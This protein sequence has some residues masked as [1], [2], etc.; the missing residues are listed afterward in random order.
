ML[1]SSYKLNQDLQ[2]IPM[3][4][5]RKITTAL[6]VKQAGKKEEVLKRV[7]AFVRTPEGRSQVYR[8]G[9]LPFVRRLGSILNLPLPREQPDLDTLL[10]GI[11]V[12]CLCTDKVAAP[13]DLIKCI[14]CG[15]SQH[16]EC[17]GRLVAMQEYHCPQC[18]LQSIEPFDKVV[19]TVVPATRVS[20]NS[21]MIFRYSD[22]E[23]IDKKL[24]LRCVL[25]DEN[26]FRQRWPKD[27]MVVLNKRLV[28]DFG[29]IASNETKKRIRDYPL[30]VNGLN[31][32]GENQIAVLSKKDP[33]LY[34]FGL[35]HVDSVSPESL[36]STLCTGELS[37]TEGKKFVSTHM[38]VCDEVYADT[39]YQVLRCPLSLLLPDLPV[40]G[41]Y[42]QHI[43][44]FD[45]ATYIVLQQ[46]DHSRRWKCPMCQLPALSVI[47][48]KYIGKI[49][50]EAKEIG[51]FSVEFESTGYYRLVLEEDDEDESEPGVVK[52]TR[53]AIRKLHW[54]DFCTRILPQEELWCSSAYTRA[55]LC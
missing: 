31:S 32:D 48:D 23:N 11:H 28:E 2:S 6:G 9:E 55:R 36:I 30:T 18:Q 39:Y 47:Q 17:I 41:Q 40:R 33:D 54:R 7:L 1:N 44:C 15:N 26:G 27:C 37:E 3:L 25:F 46:A 52:R 16:K 24:Q 38:P 12:I 21:R 42:C 53:Y 29:Q 43:Q 13:S 5:W 35:F 51:A 10:T 49:V 22:G 14:K 34:A 19:L 20:A 50:E 4:E 45:L 8:Q